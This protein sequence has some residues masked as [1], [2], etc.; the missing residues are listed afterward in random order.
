M[1]HIS[2]RYFS[3]GKYIFSRNMK[4]RKMQQVINN[5]FEKNKKNE[6]KTKTIEEKKKNE[7]KN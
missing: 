5:F 2:K 3:H 1:L 4:D 6:K 7:T